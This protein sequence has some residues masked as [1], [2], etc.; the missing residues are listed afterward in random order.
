MCLSRLLPSGTA[1]GHIRL[2]YVMATRYTMAMACHRPSLLSLMILPGVQRWLQTIIS[3]A[4]ACCPTPPAD[5]R[6]PTLASR[7]SWEAVCAG[8][9]VGQRPQRTC[10]MLAS[11]IACG[12]PAGR[13][14]LMTHG[15]RRPGAARCRRPIAPRRTTPPLRMC[16]AAGIHGVRQHAT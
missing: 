12:C 1:P 8:C 14:Q 11:I 15:G 9:C 2:S 4:A 13:A 6:P 10:R 5:A 16:P 3:C 7:S